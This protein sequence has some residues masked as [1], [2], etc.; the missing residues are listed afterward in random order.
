[1]IIALR[2]QTNFLFILKINESGKRGGRYKIDLIF[3][4]VWFGEIEDQEPRTRR[5]H[6][7]LYKKCKNVQLHLLILIC[8]SVH[9]FKCLEKNTFG[10]R[11]CNENK[12]SSYLAS[13][14]ASGRDEKKTSYILT[15]CQR[16]RKLLGSSQSVGW[17][18]SC[19]ILWSLH[20][21]LFQ[22]VQHLN[23]FSCVPY[24]GYFQKGYDSRQWLNIW[25]SKDQNQGKSSIQT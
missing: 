7:R 2:I 19:R 4:R 6:Q 10:A 9:I 14:A 12:A 24:S 3:F 22:C 5:Q 18:S 23:L 25:K 16:W 8:F 15:F 11:A 21:P 13:T 20:A 1:M 17:L